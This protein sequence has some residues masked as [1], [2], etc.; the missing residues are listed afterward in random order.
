MET[1]CIVHDLW[2]GYCICIQTTEL[3]TF[4]T[5]RLQRLLVPMFFGMWTV[6]FVGGIIT[7]SADLDGH[8]FIDTIVAFV[9]HVLFTSFVFWF[10]CLVKSSL[11]D[12]C[13]SSELVFVFIIVRTNFPYCAKICG[14]QSSNCITFNVYNESRTGHICSLSDIALNN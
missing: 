3:K 7:G 13:G 8:S 12:I 10:H 1:R 4:L 11:L 9:L 5:E 14:R 2:N 6:G